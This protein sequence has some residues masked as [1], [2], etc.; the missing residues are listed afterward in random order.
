MTPSLQAMSLPRNQVLAGCFRF[1]GKLICCV[2]S[3]FFAG[4]GKEEW[5]LFFAGVGKEERPSF[6]LLLRYFRILES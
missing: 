5:D 2:I 4:V 1:S 3:C 6:L